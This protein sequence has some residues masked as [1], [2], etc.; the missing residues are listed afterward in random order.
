M[1]GR[2]CVR[3]IGIDTLALPRAEGDSNICKLIRDGIK[4]AADMGDFARAE[5]AQLLAGGIV[6]G[7]QIWGFYRIG[8]CDLL[9]HQLRVGP[10]FYGF[11][12]KLGCDIETA[13]QCGVLCDIVCAVWEA[14]SKL[15]RW[16]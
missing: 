2:L 9:C 13:K 12:A 5:A 8:A 6:E 1:R 14:F 16:D 15:H 3:A 11:Y 7:N 4:P 10:H